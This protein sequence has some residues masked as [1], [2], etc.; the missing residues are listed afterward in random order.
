M[1]LER[2]MAAEAL[3][4]FEEV[5]RKEPNR[6]N[7]VAGAAASAERAGD[8]KKARDFSEKL[9]ALAGDAESSRPALAAARQRLAAR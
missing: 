2:G 3:A 8:R 4:Q 7:A 5:L 9:L 6:F 1:L